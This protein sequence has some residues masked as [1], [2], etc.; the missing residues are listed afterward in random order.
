MSKANY[1]KLVSR[2]KETMELS[3]QTVGPFTGLYK[4][5][6]HQLKIM[7]IP[8]L[9]IISAL[10]VIVLVLWFGPSITTIVTL[11]QKGF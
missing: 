5:I 10:L 3:P 4:R 11:L 6:T 2:W 9:V 1:H 8:A 7:P